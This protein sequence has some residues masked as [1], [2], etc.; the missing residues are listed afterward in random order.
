MIYSLARKF[1]LH[2]LESKQCAGLRLTTET[3]RT[4]PLKSP[5][6]ENGIP[7]LKY[8][9][10]RLE[11]VRILAQPNIPNKGIFQDPEKF[12]RYQL[13][14]STTRLATIRAWEV[15]KILN[16]KFPDFY[17]NHIREG[18][19][20]TILNLKTQFNW[21]KEE[22]TSDRN[23]LTA[24]YVSKTLNGVT[25]AFLTKNEALYLKLTDFATIYRAEIYAIYQALRYCDMN[26]NKL[27]LVCSHFRSV[28]ET[29][30]DNFNRKPLAKFV[31]D[32]LR[33]L[34]RTGNQIQMIWTP[35]FVVIKG[36]GVA[37]EAARKAVL[38][39]DIGNNYVRPDDY[40]IYI[41]PK[42]HSK[43]QE[44]WSNFN[45]ELRTVK[46]TTDKWELDTT[47]GQIVLTRL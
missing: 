10:A 20:W 17:P 13:R 44:E 38:Y 7:R 6:C 26:K 12:Q 29:L 32:P 30:Q 37:D 39:E 23:F 24:F 33:W 36:N 42:L 43:C 25:S 28:L 14:Q 1:Q 40:K 45:A 19:P 46:Q 27:L 5:N 15:L 22:E 31:L 3:F 11:V 21:A 18:E 35:G 8:R 47:K 4:T 2:I 34:N 9:R 16:K 41:E